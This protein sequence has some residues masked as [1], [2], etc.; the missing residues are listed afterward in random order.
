MKP[1]LIKVCGMTNLEDA[2]A[3]ADFGANAVGFIFYPKSPRYLSLE[4]AC[5]ISR[6]L[7]QGVLTFSVTVNASDEEIRQIDRELKPDRFQ[8]HGHE[9]VEAVHALKVN[10]EQLIKA[11]G[12]PYPDDF[13]ALNEF[14]VGAFLLDKASSKY[15]GTGEVIDWKVA[16]SLNHALA[17]YSKPIILSGGLTPDNV[18]QAIEIVQPY[19]VDVCSGVESRPGRK[20]HKKMRD[21]IQR[22]QQQQ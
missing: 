2:Q 11:V 17:S 12:I 22:C 1:S 19:G 13:P 4:A 21:W 10:E 5:D 7:P 8:L 3:A 9:S 15:G 6:Q 16:Q 18:V 14:P 20:D